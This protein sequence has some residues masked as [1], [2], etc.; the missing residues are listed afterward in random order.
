MAIIIAPESEF[1]A[2]LSKAGEQHFVE[3]LVAKPA[4]ETFSTGILRRFA[5]LDISPVNAMIL[6]PRQYCI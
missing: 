3:E 2:H 4:V 5:G 1:R 6:R